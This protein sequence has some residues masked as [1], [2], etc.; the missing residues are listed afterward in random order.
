[1]VIHRQPSLLS[2][3]L[4][5]KDSKKKRERKQKYRIVEKY[6]IG[7]VD[8]QKEKTGQIHKGLKM[9]LMSPLYGRMRKKRELREDHKA[10]D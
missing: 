7:Y 6:R 4:Y 10:R 5:Q 8:L 2:L 1:M 9:I 3:S